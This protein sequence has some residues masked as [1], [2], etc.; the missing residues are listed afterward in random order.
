MPCIVHAQYLSY[1][2][3]LLVFA[4]GIAIMY[5]CKIKGK[6]KSKHENKTPSVVTKESLLKKKKKSQVL[7][8]TVLVLFITESITYF[9]SKLT[10]SETTEAR[11]NVIHF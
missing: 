4:R 9:E 6:C 2:I 7:C 3:P 10:V 8:K 11:K 1:F 5:T